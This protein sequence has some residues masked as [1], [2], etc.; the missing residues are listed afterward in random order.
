MSLRDARFSRAQLPSYFRRVLAPAVALIVALGTNV[1]AEAFQKASDS[2]PALRIVVIEGED[3]VNVVQQKTAVAPVIEV[4]DRNDQPIAGVAVRFAIRNGHA[5]FNGARNLT[6]ISNA[7]GRA[8]ASGL[9]PTGNGVLQIGA[10]AA[11]QGQTA[12]ITIAQTN[13]MTLAQAAAATSA[14]GAGGGAGGGLSATT[15][16][17]VGG[18]AAAGTLVA[19]KALSGGGVD[20]AGPY[21]INTLITVHAGQN[22]VVQFTCSAPGTLTGTLKIQL[23]Q[24]DNGSVSGSI[25]TE[26]LQT[27]STGSCTSPPESGFTNKVGGQISGTS[28]AIQFSESGSSTN[29]AINNSGTG[30]VSRSFAFS[31]SLANDVI[32]GTL[33]TGYTWTITQPVVP[34]SVYDD[35]FPLSSTTV[36]LIKQ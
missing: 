3:A 30:I 22:G 12:A 27:F 10:S 20:Y 23:R 13:V 15:I 2:R 17:I 4:R 19:T 11:F 36:T 28:G 32:T 33:S 26:M 34:G 24:Q 16:G 6:V 18:A 8:A 29:Q 14:G 9:V 5:T 31:G 35:A 21:T 7:A 25:T 1:R